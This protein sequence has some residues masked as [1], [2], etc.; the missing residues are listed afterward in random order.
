MPGQGF[1]GEEPCLGLIECVLGV[2]ALYLCREVVRQKVSCS[3]DTNVSSP[4][5]LQQPAPFFQQLRR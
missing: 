3:P 5:R 4:S 2:E 1:I